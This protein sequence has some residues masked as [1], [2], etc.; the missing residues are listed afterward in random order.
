M[1]EMKIINKKGENRAQ[2]VLLLIFISTTFVMAG[3]ISQQTNVVHGKVSDNFNEAIPSVTVYVKG[4]TIGTLTN[5]DGDYSIDV[6]ST[7]NPILVFS[8][9]G[10]Q[11]IEV[12]VNRRTTINVTME[13][14][15]IGL[16]ELVAVGYASTK[17]AD[18]VG[19]VSSVK[20]EDI[21]SKP[22]GSLT[23]SLTGQIPGLIIRDEGGI[24]GST[25]GTFQIR[26]LGH[27]LVIVDGMQQS[28]SYM[29]PN[30]IESITVLKDASAAVYGAR[31]GNGVILVTTKR[32]AEEKQEFNISFS[33]TMSKPTVFPKLSDAAGYAFLKNQG[34]I[35][36]GL[37]PRYTEEEIEK[38][39][40]GSDPM[41]PNTSMWN[42]T[43]KEWAPM[44]D[45]NI[46]SSGGS[47]RANYFVSAGIKDQGTSLRSGSIKFRRISLLSNVD[48]NITENL[49]ASLDLS[50]RFEERDEPGL[51]FGALIG[52]MYQSLP[53]YP[54]Y[55]PD[56]EVVPYTGLNAYNPYFAS[57]TEF[58]GYNSEKFK[59]FRGN[60]GLHYDFNNLFKGL[61]TDFRFDY[62][63]NDTFSKAFTKPFSTYYY[64]YDYDNNEYSYERSPI[65]FNGGKTTLD[66][67]YGRNWD[68][69]LN[70]KLLYQ[71]DIG[72]HEVS[73]MILYE[74]LSGRYD[75]FGAYR[76]GFISPVI[77]QIL[78]KIIAE[79]LL[80]QAD[81]LL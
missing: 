80:N 1:I 37:E 52:N 40:D 25:T 70:Y 32:G 73:G 36:A 41:Y 48:I 20:T 4:T 42:E 46:N 24:P 76:E 75:G 59:M 53:V 62:K 44:T 77:D 15:V 55:Y 34:N 51:N 49:R 28:F 30:E 35:S 47:K 26:R 54:V 33:Q 43:F 50:A 66:E 38:F 56:K 27:P 11:T 45:L 58:S 7:T 64:D 9:V 6:S 13:E 71:R 63:I 23:Q 78:V 67:S 69:L 72:E 68:W 61:T 22:V 31:A 10:M 65:T 18:I 5:V 60:F 8:F 29:D 57:Q 81:N 3:N 12:A 16:E 14:D 19:A 74:A 39:R 17:R 79:Q 21:T 2:I